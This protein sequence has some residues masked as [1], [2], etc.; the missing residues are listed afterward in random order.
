MKV[1]VDIHVVCMYFLDR[2][3][4]DSQ[5][6]KSVFTLSRKVSKFENVISLLH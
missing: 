1:P 4:K 5:D 6:V 2:V 3:A